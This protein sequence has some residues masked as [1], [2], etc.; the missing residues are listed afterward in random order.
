MS[1]KEGLYPLLEQRPQHV[2]IIMDG[3]NRWASQRH[4]PSLAGHKAGVDAVRAVIEI[5]LRQQIPTLTLFAFS[6]ENWKR[7]EEEV[8]GLMELF[9]WAL[10]RETRRLNK[11]Q[12]RL[13]IVGDRTGFSTELQQLMQDAETATGHNTRLTLNIAANYGGRWDILQASRKLAIAVAKGEQAA[14]AI[15][16]ASLQQFLCLHEFP[17]PDL[18][19]RTSGEQRLSNFLLWQLAYSELVFVDTYWPD[20]RQ[21]AFYETL[22]VFA[23]RQRR[24]GGRENTTP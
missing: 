5:A 21:Q 19:I 6:S 17:E 2:A 11:H 14:D 22:Q 16:E 15:N 4:L 23:Q 1:R 20:F 7:P 9:N 12:V 3:N 13:N 10:R 24:F 18:C 8:E